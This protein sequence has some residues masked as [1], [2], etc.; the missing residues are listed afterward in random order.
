MV[1]GWIK[2]ISNHKSWEILFITCCNSIFNF[3][4]LFSSML[5]A[6]FSNII[7]TV[8]IHCD[9][10]SVVHQEFILWVIS[11]KYEGKSDKT[12]N[13]QNL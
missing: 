2:I 12:Y 8:I 6:K 5:D 13:L 1:C 10:N 11:N 9:V 3:K 4:K 7:S